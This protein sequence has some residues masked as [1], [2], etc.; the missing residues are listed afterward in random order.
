M[1]RLPGPGSETHKQLW[2]VLQQTPFPAGANLQSILKTE[3]TFNADTSK[4]QQSLTRPQGNGTEVLIANAVW[5]N[6]T[7]VK[8]PYADSMLSLYQVGK[9]IA[10]CTIQGFFAMMHSSR[11]PRLLY[12]QQRALLC[13]AECTACCLYKLYTAITQAVPRTHQ[14]PAAHRSSSIGTKVAVDC[15]S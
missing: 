5:T 1:P 13:S 14:G 4:L 8:K 2:A 3:T 6:K 9:Y 10:F 7:P 11:E 15:T 12:Q